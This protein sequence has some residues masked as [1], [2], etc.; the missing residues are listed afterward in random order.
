MYIA[1]EI[2]PRGSGVL[3]WRFIRVMEVF[4]GVDGSYGLSVMILVIQCH[5]AFFQNIIKGIY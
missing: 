5:Y 4:I 3:L 1:R 2:V